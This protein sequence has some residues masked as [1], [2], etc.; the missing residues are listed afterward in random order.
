MARAHS[1]SWSQKLSGPLPE[2]LT[3]TLAHITPLG[4][5]DI[6]FMR[7]P[8]YAVPPDGA[9]HSDRICLIGD[10]AHGLEPFAAQGAAM[11]IE[12]A[13]VLAKKLDAFG[14][15]NAA[16]AFSSYRET[17]LDRVVKVAKRTEFNRI[18]YH[19]SGIGRMVRKRNSTN[20]KA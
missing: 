1:G 18:A 3:H 6:D 7:W 11:G 19:Q 13:Y 8:L 4:V 9:W 17:R 2:D 14:V 10:A 20:A 16:E 5:D 12:D 15:E